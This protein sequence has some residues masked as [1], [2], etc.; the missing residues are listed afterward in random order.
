[1][2]EV[3]RRLHGPGHP[4]LVP[5]LNNLAA[6]H[7]ET[8]EPARALPLLEEALEIRRRDMG[9][10]SPGVAN[11]LNTLGVVH[12]SLHDLGAAERVLRRS[13]DIR[14]RRLGE[15]HPKTATTLTNLAMVLD[16]AGDAA[17]VEPLLREALDVKRRALGPEDPD[18]A[19]VAMNLGMTLEE[20]GDYGSAIPVVR[21]T[22]A[23]LR[24]APG[25]H[26]PD[27]A[28]ALN[29]LGSLYLRIGDVPRAV[30]L[31]LEAVEIQGEDPAGAAVHNLAACFRLAGNLDEAERLYRRSLDRSPNDAGTMS[32]L[33]GV[34]KLRGEYAEAERVYRRAVEIAGRE[35]EST[36][37]YAMC[38]N[39]L[40]LLR[41]DLGDRQGAEAMYRRVVDIQRRTMGETHPDTARTLTNLAYL[42]VATDRPTA[43]LELLD[44]V[45]AIEGRLIGHVFAIGSD[46]Q[47]MTLLESMRGSL[48]GFLSLVRGSLPG[49]SGAV[50]DALDLLLLRK[51]IGA[52]A[53]AVQRDAVLGGRHPAL[54]PRLRELALL[55]M[56]IAKAILA[57]P[58][59][60]GS[61]QH[62]RLLDEWDERRDALESELAASIPEL[63]LQ[64]RLRVADRAAVAAALPDGSA[65]VEMVRFQ[66]FR[67]EAVPAR[68]EVAWGPEAYLAFVL[69][70]GSPDRVRM[71]DLGEA[72]PIDRAV[73]AYRQAVT[74]EVEGGATVGGASELEAGT[75]LREAVFDPL[76]PALGD[77][78]RLF[79]APDGDLTRL[80]FEVLPAADGG[81][82]I[83]R[84]RISYLSTGRDV[85]RFSQ[86]NGDG[87][88]EPLVAADPDFDLGG[89][90][91][92]GSGPPPGRRSRD[93]DPAKLRFERLS[94]SEV[95]G[96]GIAV[97]LGTA[98]LLGAAVLEAHAKACRSPRV[99]H[100]ATH[101]FFLADQAHDP[102]GLIRGAATTGVTGR[103]RGLEN[104]LLR[105]GLAL[106]GANTFLGGGS[107]PEEAEDGILTAE[108]V[109]GLDLL[110]TELVVLSACE[111][112]LGEVRV[113]EGVFGLR[114]AFV[115]A[116]AR[117]L[118]MS[119]WKVP[120]APTRELMEGFYRRLQAGEP[121]AEALR[122]AQLELAETYPHPWFWGAFI[123]Q[124]DPG[125]LSGSGR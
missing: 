22:V 65:L 66:M 115:L 92:P 55:R 83:H 54:A 36:A 90:S 102:E 84:Y 18:V 123:C 25:G 21:D 7:V 47:R 95:E 99:L 73:G 87:A 26:H 48:N 50:G 63:D 93:L 125:P 61:E 96:K 37:R 107:L 6:M 116:G 3:G 78:T 89:S 91:S 80:P 34:L 64:E 45:V 119:L 104:P 109:S 5:M 32:D 11:V 15:D 103:L 17:S 121:R 13:L 76:A 27:L 43:A 2:L 101:G 86:P 28:R 52:E 62:A 60:E 88:S 58:G 59:E 120:D 110:G 71:V 42:M 98:P 24:Q 39:N 69:P 113:G 30:P 81:R 31:F 10:D 14:R 100:L 4:R 70:A 111:T 29:L 12:R 112:G 74:G 106:A 9:E 38:L 8:G 56:Q 72:D 57:G 23:V 75:K 114:R 105:S 97:L 51:A 94:D 44:E 77:R 68:G 79:L 82:L 124:G 1:M 67:F 49:S 46:S 118:V 20:R 85:L 40:A 53:L 108:D 33:A 19:R 41:D 122:A 35:G 117:T 16:D